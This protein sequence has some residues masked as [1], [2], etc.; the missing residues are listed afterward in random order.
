MVDVV[1]RAVG[2]QRVLSINFA[3]TALAPATVEQR[4]SDISQRKQA[5]GMKMAV[6]RVYRFSM[7]IPKGDVRFSE[8]HRAPVETFLTI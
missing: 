4:V 1:K 3:E 2:E 5:S 7:G 6:C 8:V